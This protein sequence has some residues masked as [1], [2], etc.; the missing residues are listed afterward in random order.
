MWRA[1]VE[2]S[3]PGE[4]RA[5]GAALRLEL[6][7]DPDEPATPVALGYRAGRHALAALL[8]AMR[9]HGT[10]HVSLNLPSSPRAP[11]DVIEELAEYVLPEFHTEG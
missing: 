4:F 11:R 5:F 3:A 8:R 2:R 1:A 10:H 9:E 7:D 6:S